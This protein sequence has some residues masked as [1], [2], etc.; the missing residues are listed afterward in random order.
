MN[1]KNFIYSLQ[2]LAVLFSLFTFSSCEKD[3][4]DA[5][6]ALEL[7]EQRLRLQAELDAAAADQELERMK[8]LQ[9][10][11]H[12][13]DSLNAANAGGL[14][15]YS[16]S[17]VPGGSSAFSG[18]R[19]EEVGVNGVTVTAEQYGMVQTATTQ[20]G[21]A[22]FPQPFRSG[23]V[24]VTVDAGAQ[25]Y[26]SVH[27]TSNLTPDG[28]VPNNGTVFVSNIMPVFENDVVHGVDK[29][30]MISGNAYAELD[31]TNNFE[32][33][34]PEGTSFNAYI[35]VNNPAF[36]S[37]YIAEANEE[38]TN[39]GGNMTKSGYIQRVAYEGAAVA[40]DGRNVS[41]DG[42]YSMMVA[43]TA[44]G[45]P[46][47]MRASDFAADRYYFQFFEDD[48]DF[49]FVTK[50]FLYGPDVTPSDFF[51]GTLPTYFLHDAAF[52]LVD[53]EA[54]VSVSLVSD[55]SIDYIDVTDGGSYINANTIESSLV[56][57]VTIAA[58]PA[59]GTQATAW[60]DEDEMFDDGDSGSGDGTMY[61]LGSDAVVVSAAGAGYTTAPAVTINRIATG[62]MGY[63]TLQA[64]SNAVSFIRVIDGGYGF[65]SLTGYELNPII[66]KIPGTH[67]GG[68]PKVTIAPPAG[69][70]VTATA[71][72]PTVTDGFTWSGYDDDGSIIGFEITDTGD[73]Y[74]AAPAI[75]FGYGEGAVIDIED[76]DG[77]NLFTF[78]GTSGELTFNFSTSA[79]VVGDGYDVDGGVANPDVTTLTATQLQLSG[80]TGSFY[81]FVPTVVIGG[82][83]P[84]AG[85]TEAIV[86][87][88]VDG[89]IS[90]GSI[91]G[92][93]INEGGD[94]TGSGLPQ[95]VSFTPATNSLSAE[96]L[97]AG[98]SLDNYVITDRG[99]NYYKAN[100]TYTPHVLGD[101]DYECIFD[102]PVDPDGA[103]AEAIA[104]IENS[105]LIGIEFTDPGSMY[106]STATPSFYVREIGADDATA[107]A[108]LNDA[109][110][111][112]SIA[113]GGLGYAITPDVWCYGGGTNLNDGF[114]FQ[115]PSNYSVSLDPNGTITA[116]TYSGGDLDE[117]T[118]ATTLIA[119]V[120]VADA[121]EAMNDYWFDGGAL[122]WG[123]V[124]INGD[125]ITGFTTSSG[126]DDM[127]A[128][129]SPGAGAPIADY[130]VAPNITIF[131]ATG[132]GAT[133]EFV[134]NTQDGTISDMVV[135][136]G[137]SGYIYWTTNDESMA[138]EEFRVL[139]GDTDFEAYSGLSYVR[140]VHY[141]TGQVLE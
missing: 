138:P 111:I 10:F 13:L 125:Q 128:F 132:S 45:L 101:N 59:G 72:I 33:E 83:I 96:T 3:T 120:S 133:A 1:R 108:Y 122:G 12:T 79:D 119:A 98:G 15:W 4:F 9:L 113:N 60:V 30:A 92:L 65:T 42:D 58:P 115:D 104:I 41:A 86:V 110:L 129:W 35:D 94:Y 6:K 90:N 5:E 114:D 84:A 40:G 52:T 78:D 11:A 55:G 99:S 88:E 43:A 105:R 28:G 29:M 32:E 139:G 106:A 46:I 100:P 61:E 87:P 71:V 62:G 53:T 135:T 124:T 63:G 70:G 23:E 39:I 103:T 2:Y 85:G 49:G 14:V 112:F 22:A 21:I 97:L 31:L 37:E 121:E 91:I 127:E 131:S 73:G 134:L 64:P 20:N 8:D 38:G 51:A 82:A 17:V 26:T 137:G 80:N 27:Y 102:A 56:P 68:A 89:S 95:S 50:R 67:V 116:I 16:V 93:Q 18:G 136:N 19:Y 74:N 117:I 76:G 34:A 25:G 118:D 141:G 126:S 123:E 47:K 81:C 130:V 7:E 24:T 44:S 107:K 109:Q 140:D 69:S 75:T 57:T 77:D 48:G 54:S 66:S 36:W